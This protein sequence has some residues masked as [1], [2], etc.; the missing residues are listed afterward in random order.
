MSDSGRTLSDPP[1]E[2][3]AERKALDEARRRIAVLEAA[4]RPF[5]DLASRADKDTPQFDDAAPVRIC[6]DNESKAKPTLADARRAAGVLAC[7]CCGGEGWD[8]GNSFPCPKCG[9]KGK[10][11]A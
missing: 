4:L 5:G 1:W 8:A 6:P 10:A 2:R 7:W 9:G 11:G 3:S